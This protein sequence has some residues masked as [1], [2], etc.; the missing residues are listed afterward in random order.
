LNPVLESK[1]LEPEAA[2]AALARLARE[3]NR[4]A[5]GSLYE[6]YRRTVHG[7]L[8]VHAS[9]SDAEDLTQVV[10]VKA[11]ERLN[12]LRQAEAFAGWLMAITR[13]VAMDHHRRG[14][15]FTAIDENDVAPSTDRAMNVSDSQ[16]ALNAIRR[17]P[18]AYR[19]TLMLRL[20]EGMTGPEIA[21]RTGI[22]PESV[23][24][25]LCRG[26]KMLRAEL[27]RKSTHA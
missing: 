26:M 11:L 4:A 9:H 6:R 15:N 24:V 21:V 1:V 16:F 17:L 14:K 5:F 20:V 3:G 18:E 25:N 22:T 7:V 27:E 19:E 8:L 12:G 13:N 23:R 2:D 10:F